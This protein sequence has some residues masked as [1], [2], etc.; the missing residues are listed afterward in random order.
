[1]LVQQGCAEAPVQLSRRTRQP[2]HTQP[3]L[4]AAMGRSTAERPDLGHRTLGH[5]H[6]ITATKYVRMS[7]TLQAGV[8]DDEPFWC[9]PQSCAPGGGGGGRA[10]EH[11]TFG[12][13]M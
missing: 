1:V 7:H 8:H 2:G 5:V 11:P 4:R 10:T 6:A 3:M 12:N 13:E 9:G